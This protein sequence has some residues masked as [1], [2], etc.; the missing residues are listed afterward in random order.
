MQINNIKLNQNL[1][2]HESQ[3]PYHSLRLWLIFLQHRALPLSPFLPQLQDV[4][5]VVHRLQLQS[6]A[7]IRLT[8]GNKTE[9]VSTQQ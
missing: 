9:A 2:I 8:G 4:E 7:P 5:Q 1:G 6:A 3:K